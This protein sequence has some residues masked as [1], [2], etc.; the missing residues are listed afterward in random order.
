[1]SYCHLYSVCSEELKYI[2][3]S[4]EVVDGR[5]IPGLPRRRF[6][7]CNRKLVTEFKTIDRLKKKIEKE[8]ETCLTFKVLE[9]DSFTSLD[10][11]PI[12]W[13][14]LPEIEYFSTCSQK[15]RI[16]QNHCS[17]L[18]RCCSAVQEC[19]E[20]TDESESSMALVEKEEEILKKSAKC[21][22][23]AFNDYKKFRSR[24][25]ETVTP[26]IAT[27]TTTSQKYIT[28]ELVFPTLISIN[29][30]EP[31]RDLAKVFTVRETSNYQVTPPVEINNPHPSSFVVADSTQP[32]SFSG[33]NNPQPPPSRS[34]DNSQVSLFGD[35]NDPLL[36]AFMKADDLPLSPSEPQSS[37]FLHASST[38]QS[39]FGGISDLELSGFRGAYESQFPSFARTDN[40][41]RSPLRKI[42]TSSLRLRWAA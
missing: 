32:P 28:P 16:V 26:T 29:Q 22:I 9:S 31:Q 37:S 24:S 5:L 42:D 18:G 4:C 34:V 35:P 30:Q 17:K 2:Q 39:S 23:R 19:R 11:C 40:I 6:G 8:F 27:T 13:P 20:E 36:A 1:M 38:Q 21:Q 12:E 14:V 25:R 3:K 10:T 41:R 15:V 7:E 33:F